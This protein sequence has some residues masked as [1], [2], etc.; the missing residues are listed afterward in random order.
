MAGRQLTAALDRLRQ[1]ALRHD[2]AGLTDSELLDGFI[3]QRDEA[4]FEALVRRHGPMVLGVCQRILRNEADAEDAFQ[5]T[6]LVL[7]RKASSVRPRGMVGNWLYGVA[8]NTA[9][10]AK[11]MNLRRRQKERVAG[12]LPRQAAPQE[13]W[14]ELQTLLDQ[15]L[16]ALPD[17][18]RAPI[19][20]CDL[21]GKTINEAARQLGWP[22]GTV[23]T[24]LTRGRRL[25]AQRLARHGL[26]L[27]GGVLTVALA[28]GPALACL[29]ASL[30]VS[31]VQA[32]IPVAMSQAA[33]VGL[34]ST[35][36]AALTERV[37]T[38]MLLTKLK[39]LAVVLLA[40]TLLGSGAVLLACRTLGEEH[41][42]G[43][44]PGRIQPA[45]Q[46]GA[47]D[48]LNEKEKLQGTWRFVTVEEQGQSREE[49]A[50]N[51]RQ[52]IFSGDE[53]RIQAGDRTMY[54]G[55]F[56]IDPSR[57][58]KTMDLEITESTKKGAAG[59]T[60]RAIYVLEGDTLKWCVS[61]P[62][63]TEHPREF[64][65]PAGAKIMLVTLK[66]EGNKEDARL[67]GQPQKGAKSDK[68]LIQGTW[69]VISAA[70]GG[71]KF[72]GENT[73]VIIDRETLTI[74][75]AGD[76]KELAATYELDPTQKP[77]WI[78]LTA[79]DRK[80]LGIYELAGDT[81]KICVNE[82][83]NGERSTAFVSEP[84]SPNDLLFVLKREKP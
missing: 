56:T 38:A 32:A 28:Q 15:E 84:D 2:G 71:Q 10:H 6:F 61:E 16:T 62:G 44:N 40:I 9:R 42:Q 8:H 13:A 67:E 41:K 31:T 60:A 74:L 43:N 3:A 30:V 57:K 64:S 36:V 45:G 52:L 70:D 26:S 5:A 33:A 12:A 68:E 55:K 7:V 80:M 19:V 54:L 49:D 29:P 53:F 79:G 46:E 66:R 58:P 65:A 1:A 48:A 50:N 25:L 23:A 18:Y 37:V 27:S 59:T 21:E 51:P 73:R 75:K 4:A 78:D 34:V 69:K 24:R 72:E 47:A 77:K 11:A 17:K 81:L 76:Q 39:A 35:R 22:Q 63:V 82:R 20:L 83:P 14:G